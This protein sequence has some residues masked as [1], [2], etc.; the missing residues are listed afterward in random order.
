MKTL[1]VDSTDLF[2]WLNNQ[3]NTKQWVTHSA[4]HCFLS[5]Y[6]RTKFKTEAIYVNETYTRIAKHSK[7]TVYANPKWVTKLI[8]STNQLY[9]PAVPIKWTKPTVG[10]KI[11]KE[12]VLACAER[13]L[14]K[15]KKAA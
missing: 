12:E 10:L 9:K 3:P 4:S 11:S 14:S 8:Q 15:Q 1:P 13:L 6:L 5:F 2:N 7:W